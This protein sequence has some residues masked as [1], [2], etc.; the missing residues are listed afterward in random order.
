MAFR[1]LHREYQI[2]KISFKT[3]PQGGAWEPL[4][5]LWRE[6]DQMPEL[7]AGWLFDHFYPILTDDPSGPCFEGWTALSYLA[8]ITERLRLGLMVSA[9]PY[10]HPAVLAN[11]CAT[12]DVVSKGRLEIGLGAGWNEEEH[13]AY[14]IP[15]PRAGVRLDALDEA[16]Q[17]LDSLLTQKV[18]N[19][20]G[21][22]YTITDAFC[23]PKGP[24]DP[25]PPLVIGGGGEK[26]TLRIV[27]KYADHWNFPGRTGEELRLKLEVLHRHCAEVGRDPS[28]IE[29]SAHLFPPLDPATCVATAKD[30]QAAGCDHVIIYMAAP[31][32][33]DDLRPAAEALADAV[34]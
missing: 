7:G 6:A 13:R 18:T 25:R 3:Q 8:G 29:V 10:R 23:E 19:F 28:E 4:E 17:I 11:I 32:H 34:S 12:L 1:P 20:A 14:G 22:H 26:R 2:M 24:Q 16:C 5:V 33:I 15:F 30:L 21:E 27:A 31:F 9:N